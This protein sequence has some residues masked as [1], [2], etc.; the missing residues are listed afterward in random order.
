MLLDYVALSV[1]ITWMDVTKS[2]TDWSRWPAGQQVKC[3]LELTTQTLAHSGQKQL[4][5]KE[6]EA[7]LIQQITRPISFQG[8]QSFAVNNLG[9]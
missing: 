5:R 7:T 2:L 8:A 6:Q 3:P 9:F 1:F 4:Q